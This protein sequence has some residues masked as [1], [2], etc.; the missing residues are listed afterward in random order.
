M[1]SPNCSGDSLAVSSTPC[2]SS[3]VRSSGV[4]TAVAISRCR[5]NR[6]SRGV[7]AGL[8]AVVGVTLGL[9]AWM[10]A[11]AFGQL[12]PVQGALVQEA[13]DLAVILNALRALR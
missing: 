3:R 5:R 1:N 2:S 9:A 10:L 4:A 6:D 13:I 12:P 11:A 7:A 8:A